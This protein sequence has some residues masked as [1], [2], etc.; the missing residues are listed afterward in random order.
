MAEQ[1]GNVTME[2]AK[3]IIVF[4]TKKV[5]MGD[6]VV[7][8]RQFSTLISAGISIIKCLSA[9]EK[10]TENVVLKKA[11]AGIRIDIENGASLSEAMEKYPALF[12]EFFIALIKAAEAAGILDKVLLRLADHLEKQDNLR[13]TVRN[14]FS[15]PVVVGVLSILVVGFL[16]IVIVP[17][18]S[19]IYKRLGVTLPLPTLALVAFSDFVRRFWWAI[20]IAS[21]AGI[22]GLKMALKNTVFKEMLDNIKLRMP[23]FGRLMRLSSTARFI[24]TFG[25]MI[26]SGIIIQESLAVA[27]KVANNKAVSEIVED[28]ADNVQN[29]KLISEALKDQNIFPPST[30]QMIA[31]GE[32]SGALDYMLEKSADALERDVDDIV[33]RLVVKIEPI[34]T[35]FMAILVGFIAIAI[36]L[37]IFDVMTKMTSAG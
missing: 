26:S 16:V 25:D 18:F 1:V 30:V 28:M 32:E 19:D 2:R 11:V 33:K 20:L 15:Y 17:V 14:A 4:G 22:V 29:G 3:H 23:V 31:S 21:G 8:I 37:P 27:D 9:L 12:S 13:R 35:F 24:R 10:Q 34:M 7:F 5:S 36:Y 6:L